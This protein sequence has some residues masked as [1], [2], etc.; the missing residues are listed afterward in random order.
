MITGVICAAG[1]V[2]LLLRLGRATQSCIS[3]RPGGSSLAAELHVPRDR[4]ALTSES[5]D[6]EFYFLQLNSY[7]ANR[8]MGIRICHVLI[9]HGLVLTVGLRLCVYVPVAT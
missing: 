4:P 8:S 6:E 7:V 9:T 1:G 2:L 3:S 5:S